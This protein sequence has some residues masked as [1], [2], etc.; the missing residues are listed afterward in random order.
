MPFI[1]QTPQLF[2]RTEIEKL[3]PNQPGVYGIFRQEELTGTNLLN[4]VTWIYVGTGDIR[5]RLLD[6]IDGD[7]PCINREEPT[8]WVA[9]V[10]LGDP[11]AREAELIR[12]LNPVCNMRRP[13]G[14]A[15]HL[16]R[17]KS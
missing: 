11:S 7:N 17:S 5:Q 13:Q 4:P 16:V 10:I 2:F 8:H 1:Q 9:E 6:H 15:A 12:E 3:A 14:Q